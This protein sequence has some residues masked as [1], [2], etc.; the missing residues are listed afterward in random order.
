MNKETIK[1]EDGINVY[2]VGYLLLPSVP[3]EKVSAEAD[4]LKALI[5]KN[6]GSIISD[7]FPKLRPLAYM[8]A[9][10]IDGVRHKC[11][12]G[13]FGWVKFEIESAALPV[14]KAALDTHPKMLRYL[15]VKT[16]R[17]NTYLGQKAIPE[18]KETAAVSETAP[19]AEMVA[20][21]PA[22]PAASVEEIDKTIEDMVK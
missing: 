6:K 20:D 18:V 11:T 14:I 10:Q 8:M 16:V 4:G 1:N 22:A 15:L 17:E 5:E 7:E 2:E 13:Y 3:A 12:E 9:K 19:A 21:A